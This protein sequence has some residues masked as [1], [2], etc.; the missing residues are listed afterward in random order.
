VLSTGVFLVVSIALVS[1][2]EVSVDDGLF[3][4]VSTVAESAEPSS[5]LFDPHPTMA[6][7]AIARIAKNFNFIVLGVNVVR[8]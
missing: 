8:Q 7:P 1:V 5:F 6:I 3:I 2:I 4:V